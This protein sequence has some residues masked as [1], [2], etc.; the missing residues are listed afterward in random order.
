MSSRVSLPKISIQ[1]DMPKQAT[2]A[3]KDSEALPKKIPTLK[4]RIG[5]MVPPVSVGSNKAEFKSKKHRHGSL[6]RA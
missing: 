3:G 5:L 4:L 6:E 1:E 2:A